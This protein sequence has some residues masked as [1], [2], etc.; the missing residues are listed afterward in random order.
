MAEKYRG[1]IIEE[2]LEDKDFFK[3]IEILST[4]IDDED[5]SDIWHLHKVSVKKERL[6][7][8]IKRLQKAMTNKEAWYAH[9]YKGKDLV[10]V[11]KDKKFQISTD[12]KSW[13]PTIS[14]GLSLGIPREQLDFK[15]CRIEDEEW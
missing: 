9:F 3:E 7:D 2:S 13:G 11:F 6:S 5:P 15:P 8:I 14:Y 4:K 12:K 10:V 1:I